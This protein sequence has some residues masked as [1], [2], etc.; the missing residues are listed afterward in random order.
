MTYAGLSALPGFA[1]DTGQLDSNCDILSSDEMDKDILD[2]VLFHDGWW[3]AVGQCLEAPLRLNKA[4]CA[5]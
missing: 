4:T 3:T 1:L 5:P 2:K